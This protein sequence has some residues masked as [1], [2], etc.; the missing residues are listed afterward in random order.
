MRIE[1]F[2]TRTRELVDTIFVGTMT[3][4]L[5]LL[6]QELEYPPD[7]TL[8]IVSDSGK[9]YIYPPQVLDNVYFVKNAA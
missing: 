3:Y 9:V 8:Q 4:S 1:V 2:D 7:L 6:L 5:R